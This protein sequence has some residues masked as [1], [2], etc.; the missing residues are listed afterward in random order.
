MRTKWTPWVTLTNL[1]VVLLRSE[2]RGKRRIY[3]LA[4][5]VLAEDLRLRAKISDNLREPSE[6]TALDA[7]ANDKR[8]S[9]DSIS[10]CSGIVS[11]SRLDVSLDH[12]LVTLE[13]ESIER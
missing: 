12:K 5:T 8:E 6:D 4:C 2:V 7:E 9:L 1:P 13:R 3:R 11:E 10:S